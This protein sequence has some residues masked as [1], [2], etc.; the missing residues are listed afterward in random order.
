MAP[1]APLGEP[2]GRRALA[3]GLVK[4]SSADNGSDMRGAD[5]PAGYPDEA[6][7]QAAELPLV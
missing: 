6:E 7:D 1:G 2:G 5:I 3:L 4:M